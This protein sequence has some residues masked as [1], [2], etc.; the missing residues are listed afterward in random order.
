MKEIPILIL[1]KREETVSADA[2]SEW[3]KGI[4]ESSDNNGVST[5]R[6]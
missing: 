3:V 2:P 5:V 4:I 6:D 1:C